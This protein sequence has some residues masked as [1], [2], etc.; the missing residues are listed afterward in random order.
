MS[1]SFKP[2]PSDSLSVHG[3]TKQFD[4]S[5]YPKYIKDHMLHM[6]LNN[7]N[8]LSEIPLYK[9]FSIENLEHL[10]KNSCLFID[11]IN[12]SWEDCYENFFLKCNFMINDTLS[13][14][15]KLISG[16]FGQ[17][18]TTKEES[19]AMWRIYSKEKTGIKIKTN[20]FKLFKALYIDDS[21]MANTWFGKVEYNTMDN[22]KTNLDSLISTNNSSDV[23]Q[24]ILPKT[25]FMKRNEFEHEAEFRVIIM[26]DSEQLK[27]YK[28][29]KRLAYHIDENF[30]EEFCLDP[31]LSEEKFQ[32]YKDKL[33]NLGIKSE[34]IQSK[35]YNFEPYT[36]NLD[37]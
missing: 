20:A 8:D 4:P 35:L 26:L 24:Q 3:T 13:S 21:C 36:F 1:F 12:E 10:I 15:D 2:M 27:G 17:S 5:N 9:Y 23:F 28:Q 34:I 30:I 6:N 11:K 25:E 31:R 7:L 32:Q 37:Q 18:W 16:I 22:F 33:I 19:D 29:Y 14:G